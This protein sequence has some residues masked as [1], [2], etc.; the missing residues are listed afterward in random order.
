[1]PLSLA[2]LVS[3]LSSRLRTFVSV[4][5][6]VALSA[7]AARQAAGAGNERRHPVRQSC[8][9][10]DA[11]TPFESLFNCS[12]SG[13]RR[14]TTKETRFPRNS[15]ALLVR[16]SAPL[17]RS[18]RHALWHTHARRHD[19]LGGSSGSIASSRS[20]RSSSLLLLPF[21]FTF[22]SLH[23]CRD[24][25][26]NALAIVTSFSS[27]SQQTDDERTATAAAALTSHADFPLA[28][29]AAPRSAVSYLSC[30][31]LCFPLVQFF[32]R[33]QFTVLI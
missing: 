5:R 1:M 17:V 11:G 12:G 8:R 26:A 20:S 31:F 24:C 33:L 9:Q 6:P 18:S 22:L 21:S 28:T 15:C 16:S 23:S 7:L 13:V 2:H 14:T 32:S 4:R 3:H 30:L 27:A 19:S 10:A 29:R 25:T